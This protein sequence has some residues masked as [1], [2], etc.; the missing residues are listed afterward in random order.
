[1]TENLNI[2]KI[3]NLAIPGGGGI[4]WI[5]PCG[6]ILHGRVFVVLHFDKSAVGNGEANRCRAYL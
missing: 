2:A 6:S 4:L 5:R 1:M 3:N